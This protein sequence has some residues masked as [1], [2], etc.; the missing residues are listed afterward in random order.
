M[1]SA[2]TFSGST[3]GGYPDDHT[4]QLSSDLREALLASDRVGCEQVLKQALITMSPLQCAE[5]LYGPALH[6]IGEAWTRGEVALAQ[7]Y[8]CGRISEQ[9]IQD[10]LPHSVRVQEKPLRLGIA[11]LADHHNLG[12]KIVVSILRAAGYAVQDYGSGLTPADLA[13]RARADDLQALL[14]SALMLPSALQVKELTALLADH[15][16]KVF[17]GGAPFLFDRQLW[18]QVGADAMGANAASALALLDDLAQEQP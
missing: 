6:D 7:L 3:S 10:L 12:K 1:N 8:V 17:V 14:V 11:V 13:A 15:P 2:C 4:L 18:Q 9:Q 16:M 5:L